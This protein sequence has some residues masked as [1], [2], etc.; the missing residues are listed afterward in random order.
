VL[1]ARARQRTVIAHDWDV[2][3]ASAANEVLFRDEVLCEVVKYLSSAS[4]FQLTGTCSVIRR[5]FTGGRIDLD[6]PNSQ[7]NLLK[8]RFWSAA[9]VFVHCK[10][11]FA[12]KFRCDIA[13]RWTSVDVYVEETGAAEL[14]PKSTSHTHSSVCVYSLY[15]T[16]LLVLIFFFSLSLTH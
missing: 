11:F 6:K 1:A 4:I 12:R 16:P 3:T 15:H 5:K 2:S 9:H 8:Y 7:L 10:A 14:G 13:S